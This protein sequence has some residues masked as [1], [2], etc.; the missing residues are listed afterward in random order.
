[1][2]KQ[3]VKK[4]LGFKNY[5]IYDLFPLVVFVAFIAGAIAARAN[6]LLPDFVH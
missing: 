3:P 6:E 4:K 2:P 1:M 5:L